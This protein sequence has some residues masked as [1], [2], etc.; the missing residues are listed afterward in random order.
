MSR[1]VDPYRAAELVLSESGKDR[2]PAAGAEEGLTFHSLAGCLAQRP[3]LQ[4]VVASV[5]HPGDRSGSSKRRS[6]AKV[7]A[8]RALI[9]AAVAGKAAT[10]LGLL[11]KS[12]P[13]AEERRCL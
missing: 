4:A 2:T 11:E 6:A 10:T 9:A 13:V 5:R 12:W 8:E 7:F 1:F 3:A